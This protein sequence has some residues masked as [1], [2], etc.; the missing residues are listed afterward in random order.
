VVLTV[1]I[2][3]NSSVFLAVRLEIR[4]ARRSVPN[5]T[6]LKASGDGSS[7]FRQPCEFTVRKDD[8]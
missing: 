6:R 8:P 5:P 2:E 3:D 7:S 1:P 4:A